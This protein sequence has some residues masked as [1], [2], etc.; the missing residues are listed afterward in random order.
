VGRDKGLNEHLNPLWRFLRSNLGR[1]WDRV[2]S[3]IRE[4]VDSRSVLGAHVLD[5]LNGQVS[6]NCFLERKQLLNS[7][8]WGHR[9]VFGFYVHPKTGILL[10][11][12]SRSR[13]AWRNKQREIRWAVGPD[14]DLYE[15]FSGLWFWVRYETREGAEAL[16]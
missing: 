6:T 11:T 10:E 15:T 13:K 9:P 7:T 16:V 3:E 4:R 2:Y 5:H 8:S 14:Q 1:P 12:A